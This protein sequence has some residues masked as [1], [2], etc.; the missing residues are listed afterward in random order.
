MGANLSS[1]GDPHAFLSGII[2]DVSG[3]YE[4]AVEEAKKAI[5]LDPDFAIGY[6]QSCLNYVYLGRLE[7]AENT[8]QRASERK[9]EIA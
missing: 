4:K 2:Y 3:K 9:L 6:S 7:E 1:R 5:E 8:L